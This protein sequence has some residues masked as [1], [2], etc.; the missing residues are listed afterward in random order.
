[1][2]CLPYCPVSAIVETADSVVKIDP[3]R[4]YECGVCAQA[5]VCPVSA[6]VG[7]ELSWPR[8]LRG[9]FQSLY[10][11]YHHPP[12]LLPGAPIKYSDE[13]KVVSKHESPS[14][15]SNDVDGR[16]KPGETEVIAEMGRP[17]LGTSFGDMQKVIQALLPAGLKLDFQYPVLDETRPITDLMTD[18]SRGIFREEILEEKVG[19]IQ[20]KIT[21]PDEVVLDVF[22][23]LKMVATEIDTVFAVDVL[24]CVV[25]SPITMADRLADEIGIKPACNC[26]TNVGLGRPLA[27]I[28]KPE[29]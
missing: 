2:A 10:A 18:T 7:H 12:T 1:M 8:S 9:K 17:H 19:W 11:P 15:L 3:E 5:E 28:N 14:V 29:V 25:N 22:K 24:T 26:K 20:I 23:R 13:V 16:L 4:C 27:R 21:V 6:I